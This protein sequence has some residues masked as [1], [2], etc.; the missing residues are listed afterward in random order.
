MKIQQ[1]IDTIRSQPETIEFSAVMDC[2]ADNYAYTA[3]RFCNGK[4]D[5]QV[6]NEAGTNEGSC[7]IFAFARLNKL[8]EVETLA[9]FG[10]YYRED[11][12]QHPDNTDHANIR[13]FMRHG[14]DGITFDAD[15]LADK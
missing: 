11:V 15:A 3:T 14:W 6:I 2:I 13:T 8:N 1:L 5:D 9:C 10:N 7:K 4:G 12:L